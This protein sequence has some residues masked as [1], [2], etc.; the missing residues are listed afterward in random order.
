M[1]IVQDSLLSYFPKKLA[2]MIFTDRN[3]LVSVVRFLNRGI[4]S[5]DLFA[6]CLNEIEPGGPNLDCLEQRDS[7]RRERFLRTSAATT[8]KSW[9]RWLLTA[10]PAAS[11]SSRVQA[12]SRQI[13]QPLKVRSFST[14]DPT[15]VTSGAFFHFLRYSII[16]Q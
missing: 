2:L 1:A 8:A 15:F 4:D 16:S 14:E 10:W 6:L 12:H 7:D 11:G 9:R 3:I 5:V 13:S